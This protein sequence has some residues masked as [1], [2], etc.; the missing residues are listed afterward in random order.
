M[1]DEVNSDEARWELT[2][3]RGSRR[4]QFRRARQIPFDRVL[5]SIEAMGELVND[6]AEQRKSRMRAD[7]ARE[8][9]ASREDRPSRH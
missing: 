5:D 2:T 9:P 7:G 6:L 3:Y 8:A 1:A 4:E